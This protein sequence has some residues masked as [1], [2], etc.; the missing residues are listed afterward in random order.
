MKE[1]CLGWHPCGHSSTRSLQGRITA[2]S[3][4]PSHQNHSCEH[5]MNPSCCPKAAP[6]PWNSEISTRQRWSCSI[7]TTPGSSSHFQAVPPLAFLLPDRWIL[8][9]CKPSYSPCQLIP[10]AQISSCK[11]NFPFNFHQYQWNLS[12]LKAGSNQSPGFI[13]VKGLALKSSS[14]WFLLKIQQLS[15]IF[16]C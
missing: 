14:Q 7:I 13:Q 4:T 2:G 16:L 3:F 12:I 5:H 10:W 6:E 1:Q 15:Q 8:S 9:A 11:S